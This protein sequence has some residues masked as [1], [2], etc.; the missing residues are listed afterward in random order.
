MLKSKLVGEAGE[1]MKFPRVQ[2]LPQLSNPSWLFCLYFGHILPLSSFAFI[3]PFPMP[4]P[5][6]VNVSSSM[7]LAS[8]HQTAQN[9]NSGVTLTLLCHG[10][11]SYTRQVSLPLVFST[12][13][14]QPSPSPLGHHTYW[15]SA[16][17]SLPLCLPVLPQTQTLH[18]CLIFLLCNSIQ[19]VCCL[20]DPDSIREAY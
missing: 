17:F 3:S 15:F 13:S 12:H 9:R 7:Y 4:L 19:R 1:R 16:D 2:P 10:I 11:L 14:S 5:R 18:C 8:L 20:Q 6:S